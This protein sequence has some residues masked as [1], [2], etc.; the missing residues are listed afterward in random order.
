[1]LVL[2][3]LTK[4]RQGNMDVE[5]YN[6]YF[7]HMLL[8]FIYTLSVSNIILRHR[9]VFPSRFCNMLVINCVM[10]HPI[11]YYEGILP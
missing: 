5:I 3:M 9:A 11:L 7:D 8:Y 1:M 10:A 2:A 6:R 4:I